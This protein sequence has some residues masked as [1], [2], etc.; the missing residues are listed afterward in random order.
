VSSLQSVLSVSQVSNRLNLLT[1]SL[2]KFFRADLITHVTNWPSE[3]LEK[4]VRR[5][6]CIKMNP[7]FD[8]I[9][10]FQA[11]K[12]AEEVYLLGDLE[13]S[14]ISAEIQC[15]RSIVRVAEIAATIQTQRYVM[16]K[17][18]LIHSDFHMISL[19]SFSRRLFLQEQIKSLDES[20]TENSAAISY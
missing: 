10:S 20:Q 13:C 15:A 9:A 17:T 1:P 5:L 8:V 11:Q 19:L 4:Q 14:K 6:H 18:S 7:D 16:H 2:A 3:V 12:C